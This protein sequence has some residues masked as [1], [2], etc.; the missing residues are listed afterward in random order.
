VRAPFRSFPSLT[1]SPLFF[2]IYS[3]L[4]GTSL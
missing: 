2:L 4:K 3:A 1:T